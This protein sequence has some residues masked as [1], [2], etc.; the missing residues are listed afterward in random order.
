M[1]RAGIAAALALFCTVSGFAQSTWDGGGA[2]ANWDTANNWVS[3]T[4]PAPGADVIFTTATASGPVIS[5]NGDRSVNTITFDGPLTTNYEVG[6]SNNANTLF[7]ASGVTSSKNG[8]SVR[9]RP[10][11][12][13]GSNNTTWGGDGD[14]QFYV[15]GDLVGSGTITKQGSHTLRLSGDNSQWTGGLVLEEGNVNL[16]FRTSTADIDNIFGTG[17]VTFSGN[18]RVNV[19]RSG[20]APTWTNH[21]IN[22]S[23][24][25]G[26]AFRM[27]GGTQSGGVANV[28]GQVSTGANV[29]PGSR[30]SFDAVTGFDAAT[31]A[32]GRWNISGDWSGYTPGGSPTVAVGN[33]TLQIDAQ[34]A[35]APS[36]ITYAFNPTSNQP[37][38]PTQNSRVETGISTQTSKLILNGAYTMANNVNF[39]NASNPSNL[40]AGEAEQSVGATHATGTAEISGNVNLNNTGATDMNLFSQ[41]SGAKLLVSGNIGGS[42]TTGTLQ[43]NNR[44]AYAWGTNPPGS[45]QVAWRN[46]TGTVEFTGNN[47]Y[48]VNTEVKA[49]TLMIG[50]TA[51]TLGNNSDVD[52]SA[53]ATLAFN[54]SNEYTYSGSIRGAGDVDINSGT[55]FLNGDSSTLTGDLTVASGATLGGSGIIGG[56]TTI[57]GIH[58]PGNSPGIQ[59]FAGDLT[60]SG[61]SSAVEWELIGNTTSGPGTNFDRIMVGGNLNFASATTLNLNFDT[62]SSVDWSDNFWGLHN[63]REWQIWGVT[64]TTTG[65]G[66]LSIGS[67]SVDGIGGDAFAPGTNVPSSANFY[68]F[69]DNDSIYLRYE[70]LPEPT[71]FGLLGLLMGMLTLFTRPRR[72]LA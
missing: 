19:N 55:V 35:V 52:I 66:N 68:L 15:E 50:G 16:G 37:I 27:T 65:F 38:D 13:F 59:T 20:A 10:T 39:S 23:S 33:G 5:L 63:I 28:A 48:Q 56:N 25:G 51:G 45:D 42:S 67:I 72:K 21:F 8:G 34:Q 17:S 61:G 7:L 49:G 58:S 43:I 11:V 3:N 44:Y 1:L 41:E 40:T 60:Y 64:G 26:A 47:T 32:E 9:F 14:A 29:A 70:A 36:S 69:A 62:G 2:D 24:V 54:R 18:A 31:R 46:P 71:T 30:L 4:I 12:D 57:E 6:V 53:G 22:D